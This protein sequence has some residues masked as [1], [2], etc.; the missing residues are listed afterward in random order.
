MYLHR[1]YTKHLE[2]F[3]FCI[4]HWPVNLGETSL[5]S[6]QSQEL[7]WQSIAYMLVEEAVVKKKL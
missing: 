5:S 6:Q 7:C 1:C 2:N 3:S 4:R